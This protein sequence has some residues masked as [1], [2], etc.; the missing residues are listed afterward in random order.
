MTEKQILDGANVTYSF[1]LSQ[2]TDVYP[3]GSSEDGS[4]TLE[5]QAAASLRGSQVLWTHIETLTLD[6]TALRRRAAFKLEPCV[7]Y[8]HKRLP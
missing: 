3:D 4:V 2:R 6:K 7:D 1:R 8:A 5:H